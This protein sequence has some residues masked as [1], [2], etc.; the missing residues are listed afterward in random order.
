MLN[1]VTGTRRELKPELEQ[2]L[3]AYR[4]KVFVEALGWPL[5]ARD[6]LERDAFDRADTIY[7]V[8]HA[9]N[10]EVC[11]C[12]RLL[13]T[14]R[15]YLL[16]EVFPDLMGDIPLPRSPEVWELSRFAVS[17]PTGKNLSSAESWQ[18]TRGLVAKTV[19]LA[20]S[21]GAERLIAFS[22]VGNERLLR[23]MGVNVHRVSCPQLIDDKPVLAFWIEIDQQTLGALELEFT[24]AEARP[25][26]N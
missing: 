26:I 22:A 7:V 24:P 2:A 19:A 16:S 10:G 9:D 15:P 14:T 23:R 21:H 5:P 18:N 4:H 3:A 20:A 17:A 6:G 11:G 25:L 13:P 12:S 8:A 1:T